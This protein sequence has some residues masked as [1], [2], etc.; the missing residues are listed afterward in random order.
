MASNIKSLALS[1]D[2]NAVR[3]TLDSGHV[4]IVSSEIGSLVML[5]SQAEQLRIQ[6]TQQNSNLKV[7]HAVTWW[8]LGKVPDHTDLILSLCNRG[9]LEMSFR[10]NRTDSIGLLEALC[11]A[12]GLAIPE[13]TQDRH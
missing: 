8:E 1:D 11:V 13:P 7:S 5:L 10:M 4:D 3:I 6:K 2:G 12:L 9:G